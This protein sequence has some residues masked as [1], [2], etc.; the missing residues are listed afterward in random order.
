[1][2]SNG[3]IRWKIYLDRYSNMHDFSL[4]N[5]VSNIH[6][7]LFYTVSWYGDGPYLNKVCRISNIETNHPLDE[8]VLC[9]YLV[10]SHYAKKK[11]TNGF[12]NIKSTLYQSN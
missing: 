9:P 2:T 12:F 8:Y 5:I 6:G 7:I 10:I 11:Q 3:L 1:M 4:S